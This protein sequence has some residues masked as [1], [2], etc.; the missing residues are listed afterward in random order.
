MQMIVNYGKGF[1]GVEV[2]HS[3]TK[4]LDYYQMSDQCKILSNVYKLDIKTNRLCYLSR[5]K[6]IHETSQQQV[7]SHKVQHKK[8]NEL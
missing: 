3:P 6:L 4:Y 8:K 2:V 7:R 5:K 1:V